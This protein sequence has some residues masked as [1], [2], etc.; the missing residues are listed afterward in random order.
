MDAGIPVT[1][2][3]QPTRNEDDAQVILG[4]NGQI[5][6]SGGGDAG[7][8]DP[9]PQL[10]DGLTFP[11]DVPI[12]TVPPA[13]TTSIAG[14]SSED[15]PSPFDSDLPTSFFLTPTSTCKRDAEIF[16]NVTHFFDRYT[17][18]FQSGGFCQLLHNKL[19]NKRPVKDILVQRF[20]AVNKPQPGRHDNSH[21]STSA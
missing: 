12:A 16:V 11:T 21:R 4:A 18:I 2:Q 1:P 14:L 19:K 15:I 9:V 5:K 10:G 20:L 13:P 7:P 17:F 8:Q 6:L 3:Q